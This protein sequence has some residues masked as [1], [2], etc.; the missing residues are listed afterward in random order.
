MD[1]NQVAGSYRNILKVVYSTKG[2]GKAR[3]GGQALES[4]VEV[5]AR[6]VGAAIEDNVRIW[7][8]RGR[9]V[10]RDAEE[11]ESEHGHG[12]QSGDEASREESDSESVDDATT[13]RS[14]GDQEFEETKVQDEWYEGCPEYTYPWI[15]SEH[16]T[17]ILVDALT[18]VCELRRPTMNRDGPIVPFAFVET[19]FDMCLSFAA[20]SEASR[21]HALL[22]GLA[23][24]S[25]TTAHPAR[26]LR[27]KSAGSPFLHTPPE[28]SPLI[29]ILARTSSP[30]HLL[31]QLETHLLGSSFASRSFFHPFLDPTLDRALDDDEFP[32]VSADRLALYVSLMTSLSTTI[33]TSIRDA[34]VSCDRVDYSGF[35]KLS[36]GVVERL[37]GRRFARGRPQ[38]GKR[39]DR[40][41]KPGVGVGGGGD[42]ASVDA[43]GF[44]GAL[45]DR[46]SETGEQWD[47]AVPRRPRAAVVSKAGWFKTLC[48]SMPSSASDEGPSGGETEDG[49]QWARHEL[50]RS[51]E[52]LY[53]AIVRVEHE[54]AREASR[55]PD[56]V[57]EVAPWHS[58]DD[59]SSAK[60]GSLVVFLRLVEMR[61][62]LDSATLSPL[63]C[64]RPIVDA[65]S[66]SSQSTPAPISISVPV[67]SILVDQFLVPEIPFSTS[68]MGHLSP[69]ALI[70]LSRT[71]RL[72]QLERLCLV[73]D[74]L[75]ASRGPGQPNELQTRTRLVEKTVLR[76]AVE[77]MTAWTGARRGED[78]AEQDLR[79]Q[80]QNRLTRLDEEDA[81]DGD[82]AGL[83]SDDSSDDSSD[84]SDEAFDPR[85]AES[86]DDREAGSARKPNRGGAEAAIGRRARRVAATASAEPATATDVVSDSD[87]SSD[88]EVVSV[89]ESTVSPPARHPL[90]RSSSSTLGRH[91]SVSLGGT[92]RS[93]VIETREEEADEDDELDLLPRFDWRTSQFSSKRSRLLPPDGRRES[94]AGRPWK[95]RRTNQ[96]A[97]QP[98]PLPSFEQ[99]EV[100]PSP[101]CSPYRSSFHPQAL[102]A[103]PREPPNTR[104]YPSQRFDRHSSRSPS[105]FDSTCFFSP[106]TRAGL[107]NESARHVSNRDSISET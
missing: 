67:L 98:S 42:L 72:S 23:L 32:P 60:I 83:A 73:S 16:A 37:G 105:P 48:A 63:P 97:R 49:W 54:E 33:L 9:S 82:D 40:R 55:D 96:L 57:R 36:T 74:R 2:K 1:A 69:N 100:P 31:S 35:I 30:N 68:E 27:P 24:S 76:L 92:G 59:P 99:D 44:L 12:E 17:S 34:Y 19:L 56:D 4:L 21:F 103:C 46:G 84:V 18:D 7:T 95:R 64:A 11:G 26:S 71:H 88:R 107:S 8:E 91:L 75:E 29:T 85:E 10:N 3:D 90:R 15:L 80:F 58:D 81:R 47:C 39:K 13:D 45:V 70:D 106:P 6:Q 38:L 52:G 89:S 5:A 14:R 41:P 86:D 53:E 20:S 65:V 94:D 61:D 87:S 79:S 66:L 25:P 43:L 78:E 102:D 62:A 77:R 51:F 22:I 50:E 101:P 28:P 93:H 104:T